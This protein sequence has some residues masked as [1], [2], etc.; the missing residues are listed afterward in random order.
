[1]TYRVERKKWIL[2]RHTS[3][4]DLV[5]AVGVNLKYF[6]KTSISEEDKLNLLKKLKTL[7]YYKERNPLLPLDSINHRINT[8]A[9]FMFGYKD[10]VNGKK[11]FLYSPLGN[12]FLK[13]LNDNE[14]KSKI[15][16][17]MLFGL[18]FEHPH[19]GTDKSFQLYPFRLVF[20]L[21]F[22]KRLE[23]KLYAY[24][25][26]YLIVFVQSVDND[27]YENLVANML[28]MRQW[29]D[30]K[31]EEAFKEDEHTYVNAI[32][33]WDYYM[34]ELLKS[35]GIIH[36]IEGKIICR[37]QQGQ[38][39]YRRITRNYIEL[40]PN[41]LEYCSKLLNLYPAEN[42][43]LK[44]NDQ[45]RLR[46]DVVKE[47]YNFYPQVLLEEIG[48]NSNDLKFKLLTLAK[49]IEEYANNN[50]GQYAY[51]FEDVLV[52][53]FNMF[54]NLEA[55]KIG[56]SGNTDIEC[57][58]LTKRKKFDVDAKSTMNKLLS[59]N[60]GRLAEHRS[61]IGGEYTIVVTPR[62]VRAVL[63]DISNSPVV[64]I[65]ANTLSEYLY[66]NIDND[67][68]EIDYESFD[69]IITNNLG[70]DVSKYISELTLEKFSVKN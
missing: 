49:L 43:P 56:G 55:K 9:Y 39:T 27:V 50:N 33:E 25:V 46:I 5:T 61:R 21:L 3:N 14:K 20:K 19:G 4:F 60:A 26:A 64:I 30:E 47:I 22:D 13:Y 24:E 18:Q 45:E 63:I 70:K 62:Y 51:K 7:A 15:F 23:K 58:Y 59:I 35:A 40:S 41:L 67:V 11:R 12:L 32:Y 52:S 65:T 42:K 44:L 2:Y 48:E 66:N 31:I 37:L 1:M 38:N 68:R 54:Y 28:N 8:L 16:I 57:L 17:T 34:T 36:K 53:G 69:K 29:S 6:S 10:T